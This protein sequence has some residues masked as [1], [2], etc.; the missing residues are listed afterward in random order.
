ML[1]LA[2]PTGS[3]AWRFWLGAFIISLLGIESV[4]HEVEGRCLL[5][6]RW[7]LWPGW[8]LGL[9]AGERGGEVMVA[10]AEYS[11]GCA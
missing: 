7:I 6:G 1:T 5:I 8:K 2:Y 4:G 10:C 11:F 3:E 9:A